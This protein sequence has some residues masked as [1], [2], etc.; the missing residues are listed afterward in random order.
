[1]QPQPRPPY[2]AERGVWGHPTNINNV[3]TWAAIKP[4]IQRGAVWYA[5]IGTAKTKG[6]KVFALAGKIRNTGLVEVPFGTT[7][8]EIIFD[9]GGGIP[10]G[11]QFKAVQTGG[12]SGGVIPAPHLD[13]P[14]EYESL[15]KLGSIMGSGGMVVMDEDACMVDLARFFMEFCCDESCG[16]CPPCRVGTR[17]LLNLLQRISDGEAGQDE[18]ERLEKLVATV[19]E[20][21]L[22]GLGQAA[23]NPVLTTLKYFRDEYLAHLEDRRCPAKVCRKLLHFTIDPDKCV[24]C[25]DCARQCP[26]NTIYKVADQKKY[27]VVED[28][29][30]Q[31]GTCVEAC[32]YDAVIK[33]SDGRRHVPPPTPELE[34]RPARARPEGVPA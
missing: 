21:S 28:N 27:F 7:L 32:D 11:K 19:K 30:I 16:K 18:L 10:G 33:G 9:I 2:P 23:P 4:I 22:C 24:G 34:P 20:A 1:G 12:P 8:R 3:E 31:C 26:T 6:T 25:S 5:S 15:Q 17:Q 29:C 14:V 13:T